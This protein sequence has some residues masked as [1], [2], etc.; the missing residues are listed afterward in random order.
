MNIIF[1][2][3][4]ELLSGFI[5][6][7]LS[8]NTD[9]IENYD[10]IEIPDTKYKNELIKQINILRYPELIKYIKNIKDCGA[11]HNLYLYFDE[12]MN[13]K[14]YNLNEQ[15][16]SYGSVD[17]FQILI[18]KFYDTSFIENFFKK[19]INEFNSII[20]EISSLL[21]DN[22]SLN[23]INKFYD[24]DT[25]SYTIVLSSFINGGF[26]YRIQNDLY[27]V[28]GVNYINN[29]YAINIESFILKLFHEFS[30]S[31]I[32]PLVDEFINDFKNLD[33]L[34]EEALEYGLSSCYRH[35]SRVLLYEYFVR[36]NSIILSKKY[37]NKDVIEDN[38][39]YFK[40]IGFIYIED[41][42]LWTEN[43]IITK[44]KYNFRD[45]IEYINSLK[46]EQKDLRN[47]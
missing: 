38:I 25:M 26:G 6:S 41:V 4:F 24:I 32:N 2:K 45:L 16:F 14:K 1:D 40:E 12:N 3:R 27:Y 37:L 29:K 17:E 34:F 8:I 18:K 21:P 35:F 31:F 9:E 28:V 19:N 43:I 33:L 23:D 13:P 10:W 22:F 11:Y 36:A 39:E 47:S 20:S 30:H 5:I 15:V 46:I 42:I 7:Y 44:G